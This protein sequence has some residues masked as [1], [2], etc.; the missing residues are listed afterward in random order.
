MSRDLRKEAE[1]QS[2]SVSLWRL[3]R[4]SDG[5]IGGGMRVELPQRSQIPLPVP[6][7]KVGP[8]R[9]VATSWASLL[10]S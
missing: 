10:S 8:S 1:Y 3:I 2:L 6:S 5:N 4:L 7:Q 9:K